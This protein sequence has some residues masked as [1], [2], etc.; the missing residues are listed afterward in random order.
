[1]KLD[2]DDR[3]AR[4]LPTMPD[5]QLAL[6][7]LTSGAVAASPAID[8]FAE[9]GIDRPEL[10]NLDDAFVDRVRSSPHPNLAIEALR[11]MLERRIRTVHPHNVVARQRFSDRLVAAMRRYTNNALTTAE[12]IAEL[13]KLANAVNADSDRASE[14]GLTE[15][16]LAFYDAVAANRSAKRILGDAVLAAIARDL[17]RAIRAD[18]TVDWAVREQV[19]AKLRSKVKRLLA[20]HGYPPDAEPRAIELVLQ[21]TRTFAEEWSG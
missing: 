10:T 16:E 3:S 7:Q 9:A 5:V 17:V 11:I 19:Q 1:M 4:G 8:I 18:V 12:I 20:R 6:R 13:V 21:Q 14:L 2:A 15:D